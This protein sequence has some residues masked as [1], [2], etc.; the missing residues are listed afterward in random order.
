MVRLA[1]DQAPDP[2]TRKM[3]PYILLN[4]TEDMAVLQREI[5]G[6]LLPVLRNNFV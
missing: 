5:F 6:P 1:A 3:P 4:C 2:Q